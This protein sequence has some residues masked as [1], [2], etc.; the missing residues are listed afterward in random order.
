MYTEAEPC[1][2]SARA[3]DWAGIGRQVYGLSV[4]RLKRM[5]RN[6]PKK[7]TLVRPCRS[8]FTAGQRD[9]EVAGSL[10]EDETA[11]LYESL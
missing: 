3:V 6:H 11:A 1:T 8:I 9:V 4:S 7:P 5:T 2:M 10:L